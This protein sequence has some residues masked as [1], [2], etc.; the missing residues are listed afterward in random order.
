MSA[1]SIRRLSVAVLVVVA[2]FRNSGWP[3]A[4]PL[5]GVQALA[6]LGRGS[7]KAV[8]QPGPNNLAY[9]TPASRSTAE[10]SNQPA[11][12]ATMRRDLVA[13]VLLNLCTGSRILHLSR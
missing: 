6:C 1:P 4:E 13:A 9:V 11:R 7:L 8:L 3:G 5:V 12:C 10:S 2:L